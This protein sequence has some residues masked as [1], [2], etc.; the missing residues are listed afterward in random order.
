MHLQNEVWELTIVDNTTGL[1]SLDRDIND[2]DVSV[3][4]YEFII[5]ATDSGARPLS[6]SA[7]VVI[8]VLNCTEQ[9]FVYSSPY[10]YFEIREG[11]NA[12]T[13]GRTGQVLGPARSPESATFYPGEIPGN[14]FNINLN[15]SISGFTFFFIIV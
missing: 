12:F 2:L 13:D 1:I 14:P 7:T 15:V 11:V 8:R 5:V 10:F 3:G 6:G 4:Q 9:E